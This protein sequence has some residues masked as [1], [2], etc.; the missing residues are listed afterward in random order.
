M[1]GDI[2][3]YAITYGNSGTALLTG[4]TLTDDLPSEL[5]GYTFT[6]NDGDGVTYTWTGGELGWSGGL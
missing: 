3:S 2:V 4:R 1:S 5:T 6:P